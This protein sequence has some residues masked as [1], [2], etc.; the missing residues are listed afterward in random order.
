MTSR[1]VVVEF[2]YLGRSET[3]NVAV[4]GWDVDIDL[5]LEASPVY[6]LVLSNWSRVERAFPRAGGEVL[7]AITMEQLERIKTRKDYLYLE[8]KMGPYTPFQFTEQRPS[9]LQAETL[10]R[11]MANFFLEEPS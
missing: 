10:V 5:S 4:L 8:S 7:K 2:G 3:M 11:D 6:Q 1:Y 9:L